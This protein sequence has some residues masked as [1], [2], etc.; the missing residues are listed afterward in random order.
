M[1]LRSAAVGV[2]IGRLR[3][4]R[5]QPIASTARSAGSRSCF[6]AARRIRRL[7]VGG[8]SIVYCGLLITYPA[9]HPAERRQVAP[10]VGVPKSPGPR[11]PQK[12]ESPGARGERASGPS[13]LPPP[14]YLIRTITS[15]YSVSDSM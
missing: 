8:S 15:A 5:Y 3:E 13:K 6:R 1:A 4:E 12:A 7:T 2:S 14:N 11:L 10:C 9:Y